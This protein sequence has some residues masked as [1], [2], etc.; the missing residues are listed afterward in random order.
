MSHRSKRGERANEEGGRP[1]PREEEAQESD[2]VEERSS[3]SKRTLLLPSRGGGRSSWAKQQQQQLLLRRTVRNTEMK[4]EEEER[5]T[6]LSKEHSFVWE[7]GCVITD[8]CQ[9]W[10]KK[11]MLLAKIRSLAKYLSCKLLMIFS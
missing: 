11:Q 5:E 10:Q 4:R 3:R 8:L 1:R 2:E 7:L 9:Q 6:L